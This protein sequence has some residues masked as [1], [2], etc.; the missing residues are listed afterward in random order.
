MAAPGYE[1]RFLT[2]FNKIRFRASPGRPVSKF[3]GSLDFPFGF[4]PDRARAG[5]AV[6]PKFLENAELL[7]AIPQGSKC[8]RAGGGPRSRS[9]R[10]HPL[11]HALL[12]LGSSGDGF[13]HGCSDDRAVASRRAT[14][15][16]VARREGFLPHGREWGVPLRSTLRVECRRRGGK[17]GCGAQ[18]ALL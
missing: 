5:F 4:F 12:T 6:I 10:R 11:P 8:V 1:H 13:H 16:A 2:R 14:A 17:S 15:K 18:D 9:P 7:G 3:F